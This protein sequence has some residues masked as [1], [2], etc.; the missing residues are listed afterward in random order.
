M[1]P[2]QRNNQDL[3]TLRARNHF[4]T[5]RRGAPMT[6]PPLVRN[7]PCGV[8]CVGFPGC[9][10]GHDLGGGCNADLPKGRSEAAQFCGDGYAVP[11]VTVGLPSPSQR[12]L[13]WWGRG[14]PPPESVQRCDLGRPERTGLQVA[15]GRGSPCGA[16]VR[17]R[18]RASGGPGHAPVRDVDPQPLQRL[19]ALPWVGPRGGV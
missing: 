12:G 11:D 13:R 16:T 10:Q 6:P 1:K 18:A 19:L 3:R 2:K 7:G 17:G 8:L 14:L 4:A 9:R 5:T 15:D